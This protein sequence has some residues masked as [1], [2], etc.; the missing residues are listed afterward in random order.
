MKIENGFWFLDSSWAADGLGVAIGS[1]G[2]IPG[3]TSTA[4]DATSYSG[5]G[6]VVVVVVVVV[7]VGL[8]GL[9]G[10]TP[11]NGAGLDVGLCGF[12]NPGNNALRKGSWVGPALMGTSWGSPPSPVLINK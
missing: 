6:A 5:C 7:V 3:I 2:L 4:S 8:G 9:V 1:L 11:P 12:F 10:R